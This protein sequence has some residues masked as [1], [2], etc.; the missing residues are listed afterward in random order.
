MIGKC[1]FCSE[2]YRSKVKE[3]SQHK[4]RPDSAFVEKMDT[5]AREEARKR[6]IDEVEVTEMFC[7][8]V[9]GHYGDN[10]SCRLPKTLLLMYSRQKGLEQPR[11][12]TRGN[13]DH[14]VCNNPLFLSRYTVERQDKQFRGRVQ[15]GEEV[16]ASTS[17]EKNK[18]FAEQ[19]AALVAVKCRNISKDDIAWKQDREESPA[20][21][22]T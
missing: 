19:G 7:P 9:R 21:T 3:W 4:D 12:L 13:D 22:A 10:E 17:W 20:S 15:V 6:T 1:F 11:F 8:F 16:Y 2:K 14:A 18:K 5:V